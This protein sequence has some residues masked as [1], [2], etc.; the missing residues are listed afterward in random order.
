MDKNHPMN[1]QIIKNKNALLRFIDWLPD[2]ETNEQFYGCLFARKKYCPDLLDNRDKTQ[3]KRFLSTKERLYHK[4]KQLEVEIGAYQLSGKAAPQQSLVL[5]IN[6]NPRN[7]ITATYDTIINL[8]TLLKKG[9]SNFNPH[10]EV[11]NCIQRAIGRKVYLDFDVDTKDID[12][13]KLKVIINPSCLTI[14]ET[15]GGYHILV[16]LAALDPKYKKTFYKNICEMGADQIGDQLLPVP[17]CTQGG[18]VPHFVNIAE[19]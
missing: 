7:L 5:Y 15:R 11:L 3:L 18:F 16:K 6:P 9:K 8:T 14:V 4:I 13:T 2:L 10:K 12:L 17:G 1:Y 19:D